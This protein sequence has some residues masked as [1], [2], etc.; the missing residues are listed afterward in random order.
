MIKITE[1][2]YPYFYNKVNFDDKSLGI[3]LNMNEYN[4]NYSLEVKIKDVDEV[5]V[6]LPNGKIINSKIDAKKICSFRDVEMAYSS[7][8]RLLN[9]FKEKQ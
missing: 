2:Q 4:K 1:C 3:C 9:G 5:L 7:L 8:I 6:V